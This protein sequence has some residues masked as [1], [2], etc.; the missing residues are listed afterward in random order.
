MPSNFDL[1]YLASMSSNFIELYSSLNAIKILICYTYVIKFSI[2]ANI[3]FLII[4]NLSIL[5]AYN[6]Y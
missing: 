5:L 2:N 1:F 3:Y 6:N 4:E